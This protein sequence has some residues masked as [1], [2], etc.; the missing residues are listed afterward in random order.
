MMSKKT[1]T[2]VNG[3]DR[4]LSVIEKSHPELEQVRFIGCHSEITGT[5]DNENAYEVTATTECQVEEKEKELFVVV[6]LHWASKNSKDDLLSKISADY[7]LAYQLDDIKGLTE[8]HYKLFSDFSG[9]YHVW[10]FWREFVQSMTARMQLPPLTL[11][12]LRFGTLLPEE[13]S[14]GVGKEKTVKKKKRKRAVKKTVK[15]KATKK[16]SV[17]SNK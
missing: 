16:S 13:S 7:F 5:P 6:H 2:A 11:E 14:I 12:V 3:F 9:V 15:L 17:K 4:A 1:D 10:P 8:E